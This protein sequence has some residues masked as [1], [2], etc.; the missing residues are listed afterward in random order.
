VDSH[1]VSVIAYGGRL[2]YQ[3]ERKDDNYVDAG[4]TANTEVSIYDYGDKCLVFETRGLSV[5]NSADD[6]L[7]KLFQSTTGG[8]VGVVF[9]GSEGYLVQRTY[10]DC[11][12][13]DKDFKVIKKFGGGGDHY[14]NFVDAASA[15]TQRL[16]SDAREGHLSAAISHLGNISYY[17]GEANKGSPTRQN[18]SWPASRA[19]TT[20]RPRS[21]G[22]CGI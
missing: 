4:D 13:Y 5:D 16:N 10:T 22:R 17:L 14:A 1:P 6:E 15:A 7:N 21:S 9:Y 2:G 8:K 11:I 20:T 19:W 18:A 3:A 12:A